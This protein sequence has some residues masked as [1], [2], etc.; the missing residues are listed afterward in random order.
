MKRDK[1]ACDVNSCFLCKRVLK[2]WI[3]AIGANKKNF[4]FKKG[5]Q[6]FTE[7]EEV[8]G[9]YFVYSGTVKV[10]KKWGAEKELIIRF[11]KEGDIFGHRGL[12]IETVYPI[13]A[14]ALEATTVCF[15]DMDFFNS[16]LKIN[17]DFTSQLLMFYAGELQLSE[18]KMNNLAHMQVKGRIAVALLSLL[19]KFGT[20]ADGAINISLSKQDLASYVGTTYETLFR[21]LNE[22]VEKKIITISAKSIS[23]VNTEKL[24][25]LTRESDK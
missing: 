2:E 21:F 24:I 9:I 6:I 7:G 5:E 15:I 1:Y 18:K 10:Y 8:K 20:T 14:T 25:D 12:G 4:H 19:D 23:I 22:L 3:P 13:S 11:A 17:H 16:T